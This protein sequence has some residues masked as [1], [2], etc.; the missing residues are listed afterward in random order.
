M[1][2]HSGAPLKVLVLIKYAPDPQFPRSLGPADESYRLDR[3]ESVLSELDEYAVESALRLAESR[4]D[5]E[6]SVTALTMGPEGAGAAVKKALQ[7]GVDDGVLVTDE[8]LAGS[9]ALATS[10]VLAAAAQKLGADLVVTGMTS[11]DAETAVMVSMVASRLGRAQLGLADAVEFTEDATGINGRREINGSR[12]DYTVALPAVIS[13]TDQTPNPRYPNFRAILAARKKPMAT[14]DLSDLEL[15]PE[16]VG[17]AGSA[18]TV[19]EAG[20]V[21][22][23][24]GGKVITDDGEAGLSLVDFL[25]ERGLLRLDGN[26]SETAAPEQEA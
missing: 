2:T 8:A 11:T 4:P 10:R 15:R 25:Q 19:V 17:R 16:E 13:V 18:T 3:S 26:A 21:P 20:N 7:M 6:V 24:Q 14:W 5:D 22:S 9:D 1:S 23:R 12:N